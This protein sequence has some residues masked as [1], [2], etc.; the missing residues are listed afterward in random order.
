VV[1]E[2][3]SPSTSRTDR[4]EKLQEYQAT[5][6]I[7]RYVLLEQD[8]Q[9]ATVY[10]RRGTDWTVRVLTGDELLEMPEIGV[11][12]R[13]AEVYADVSFDEEAPTPGLE[14]E[15]NAPSGSRT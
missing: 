8:A 2:A 7:Q 6:S 3:L 14:I 4:I 10:L 13:L 5:A 11:E 9:A 1:F 15:R 12:F